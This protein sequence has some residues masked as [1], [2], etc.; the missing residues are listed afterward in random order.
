MNI[1]QVL[2]ELRALPKES[3]TKL[4]EIIEKIEEEKNE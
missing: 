3:L 4:K 2:E 1:N